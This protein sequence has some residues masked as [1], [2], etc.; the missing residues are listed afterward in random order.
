[1]LGRLLALAWNTFREG[2]RA[3][4]LLGLLSALLA[5][6]VA[7]AFVGQ[8][9]I[10]EELRVVADTAAASVS[11]FSVI[12]AV[13]FMSTSLHREIEQRTLFPVL[14][15]PVARHEVLIGKWAG[16]WLLLAVFAFVGG[17][18]S[19]LVLALAAGVAWWKAALVAA[20]VGAT[21]IAARR[22]ARRAPDVAWI[23]AGI[24]LFVSAHAIA[25][26]LTSEA[27]LLSHAASLS[28]M[29]GATLLALG[30]M[31]SSFTRPAVTGVVTAGIWVAGRNADM[32]EH[33]SVRQFG[34]G[35]S[36]A[37][38][39]IARVVPNF[40]IYVPTR[41]V[42]LGTDDT[43]SYAN[44]ALHAAGLAAAYTVGAM[45][46]ASWIFARRDIT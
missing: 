45:I 15:R 40:Q 13:V 2:V 7:G 26:P 22:T 34:E 44:Y 33:M 27:S 21:T 16:A 4:L 19:M 31:F 3:R 36:K 37:G 41:S 9:A 38:A 8:L 6:V 20:L 10:R 18:A 46:V 35:L 17:G 1:M 30:V 43:Q 42:L 11:L 24:V 23:V 5:A 28:L 32:L 12:A 14:S 39:M 25:A 29:E